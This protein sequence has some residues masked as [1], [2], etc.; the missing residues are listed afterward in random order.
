[1][2]LRVGL[3]VGTIKRIPDPAKNGIPFVKPMACHFTKL[4]L[5][6]LS[7]INPTLKRG[8]TSRILDF[9]YIPGFLQQVKR[10]KLNFLLLLGDGVAQAV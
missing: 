10:Y 6:F 5:L 3:E 1:M 2:G 7:F 9:Y 4:H 8:R